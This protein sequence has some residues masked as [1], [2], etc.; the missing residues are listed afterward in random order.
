MNLQFNRE[1]S[2]QET[3]ASG[4]IPNENK[5]IFEILC[6]LAFLVSPRFLRWKTLKN[7]LAIKKVFTRPTSVSDFFE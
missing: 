6:Y 4:P 1:T 2:Q 7:I 5:E 3:A